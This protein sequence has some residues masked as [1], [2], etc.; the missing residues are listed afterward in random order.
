M[1]ETSRRDRKMKGSSEGGQG[2]EGDD[3]KIRKSP[4]SSYKNAGSIP[5]IH[6][7]K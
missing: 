7:T 5:I 3:W 2:P 4:N 1:E 6:K